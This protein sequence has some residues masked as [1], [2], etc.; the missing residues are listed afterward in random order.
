MK[1]LQVIDLKEDASVI[2][3]GSLVCSKGH[4]WKNALFKHGTIHLI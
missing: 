3:F 1:C 4:I 2:R